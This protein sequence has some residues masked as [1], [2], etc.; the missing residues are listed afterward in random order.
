MLKQ[1]KSFTWPSSVVHGVEVEGLGGLIG[2][3]H[4]LQDSDESSGFAV[5]LQKVAT[6]QDKKKYI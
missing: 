6:C 2:R 3:V 5:V 1:K 4:V